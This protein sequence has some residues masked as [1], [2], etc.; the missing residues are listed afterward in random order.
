VARLPDPLRDPVVWT[1]AALAAL[2]AA[3]GPVGADALW[4]V[5]LG[6][7]IVHGDLPGSIPYATAPS[8]GWHDVPAG[9][10]VVFWAA[11]RAF[12]G[13]R[14]LVLAQAAA[15]A[16][17]FGALACGLR[18]EA[19]GAAALGVSLVVLAGA[20]PAVAVTNV[21]LFS[22]ALFP[23]LL[24]LL[25]REARAPSRR[26]WLAVPLLALWGNLHGAVLAGWA[27]LALYLVLALARRAPARAGAVLAAATLAL[28]AGPELWDTP[29]YYW[30]VFGNEAARRRVGLWTPLSTGAFDLLLVAAFALLLALAL[31][32]ARR[33]HRWEA[34]AIAGLAAATVDV[35]RNGVWLLLVAAYPAA[36]SLRLGEPRPH[37]LALAAGAVG[38]AAVAAVV[39]GP[40]DPGSRPLARAAAR[41]GGTVLA[42][43]VLGQQVALAGG[44]VWV[45]NP[46]DA[47][48]RADQRLYVHWFSGD[49]AGARALE[50]AELVLVSTASDAGRRAAVDPRLV[51]L[52]ARDGRAL[53]RIRG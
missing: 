47:F 43:P 37:R 45:D 14:G 44:R 24:G 17:A 41:A 50:H 36:R 3:L 40:P 9:A 6:D 10:Q 30:G 35:A 15:A 26:I 42:E 22:L 48:R 16:T 2:V 32:R 4:L 49:A 25:E 53:Y 33:F 19:G 27:L 11:Y 29:R 34:V 20:L 28:L 13:D 12:G 39:A 38:L 52:T 18:R 23:L 21:S 51:L 8:D 1:V 5:P 46:L 7:R 31:A